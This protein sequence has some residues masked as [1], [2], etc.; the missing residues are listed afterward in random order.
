MEF[1]R[2]Q[3]VL[4]FAQ[5]GGTVTVQA[6]PE[7]LTANLCDGTRSV[8]S[9]PIALA[10]PGYAPVAAVT[11]EAGDDGF[12]LIGWLAYAG[13]VVVGLM[14]IVLWVRLLGTRRAN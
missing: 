11:T 1:V 10:S 2:G 4:V 8:G 5:Y 12:P 3:T 9:E 14:P 6:E 13:V 7:E